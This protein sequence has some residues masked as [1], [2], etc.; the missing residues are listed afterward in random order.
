MID[1]SLE[2][3]RVLVANLTGD[4]VVSALV[5]GR[6]YDAVPADA[7]KPYVVIGQPQVLPD[8][9]SCLDGTETYLKIDGWS[10]GP[11]SVEIKR[12]GAAVVAALDEAELVL[13]GHRVPV[14]EVDQ[15]LY[16]DDPDGITKH[17]TATFRALTEPI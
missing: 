14:F 15:V 16:I 5:G 10:S 12:L 13:S 8:K 9:A 4:A 7:Q 6:V 11:Q 3:Q 17:F 1:P 2:F